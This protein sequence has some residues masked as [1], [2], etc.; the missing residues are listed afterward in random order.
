MNTTQDERTGKLKGKVGAE[1]ASQTT[2][3][4]STASEDTDD[5]VAPP[6]E[7][8]NQQQKP[9]AQE[10]R[11]PSLALMIGDTDVVLPDEVESGKADSEPLTA[12][13]ELDLHRYEIEIEENKDAWLRMTGAL[14]EIWARRLYR[15]NYR[16]FKQYCKRRWDFSRAYGYRLVNAHK[17]IEQVSTMVDG[18]GHKPWNS[19][20]CLKFNRPR[21]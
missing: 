10:L 19:P 16:S 20:R 9:L 3:G 18:V 2:G 13:E 15:A 6:G 1:K 4:S 8:R 21:C 11:R 5:P 7:V 17:T 12:Q 14:Y